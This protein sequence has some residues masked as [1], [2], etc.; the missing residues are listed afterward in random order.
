MFRFLFKKAKP[1]YP[2]VLKHKNIGCVITIDGVQKC[3]ICDFYER[4]NEETNLYE[5]KRVVNM[6]V[7]SKNYI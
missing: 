6:N 1:T 2:W 3:R 7:I 5:I 4:F